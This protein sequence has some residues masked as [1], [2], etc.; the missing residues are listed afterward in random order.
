[1]TTQQTKTMFKGLDRL[2]C[3]PSKP[4][5]RACS[6]KY[7]FKLRF[8]KKKPTKTSQTS[9]MTEQQTFLSSITDKTITGLD[10]EESGRCLIRR[11]NY[12]PFESTGF[13]VDLVLLIRFSCV[14]LFCF[15]CLQ[16]ASCAQCYRCLWIVNACLLLRCSNFYGNFKS[17]KSGKTFSL[18]RLL[19]P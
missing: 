19:F 17:R 10:Y 18:I 8:Q 13:L 1:M 14:V 11:I 5:A 6:V 16:S 3:K 4:L 9:H 15:I 12:L 7:I 2:Q